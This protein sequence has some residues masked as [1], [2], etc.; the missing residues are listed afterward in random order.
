MKRWLIENYGC[1][2]YSLNPFVNLNLE[3]NNFPLSR[4]SHH[5]VIDVNIFRMFQLEK[6]I[7]NEL[8]W[9]KIILDSVDK[10][11]DNSA[12]NWFIFGKSSFSEYEMNSLINKKFN[13]R[14]KLAYWWNESRSTY[15]TLTNFV[16]VEDGKLEK[17]SKWNRPN[18]PYSISFHSWRI[19][20]N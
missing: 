18:K 12:S 3:G 19:N 15:S 10:E 17:L 9:K 13:T 8:D 16:E 14:R 11:V 6:N 2:I 1:N 5:A 4:V 7:K 20:T